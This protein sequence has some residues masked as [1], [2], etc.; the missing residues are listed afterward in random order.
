MNGSNFSRCAISTCAAFSILSGCVGQTPVG[1]PPVTDQN[2]VLGGHRAGA[3]SRFLHRNARGFTVSGRD[4]LLDGKRFF[5]KGVDYGPT[6]A[7]YTYYTT[8]GKLVNDAPVANPLDNA[9]KKIWQADL[10]L[11]R[12]DGINAVKVYNVSLDS[13]KSVP[14]YNDATFQHPSKGETGKIDQFLD[15]AWN[16]GNHPIYVM[17]SIYFEGGALTRPSLKKTYADFYR[18][19]DKEYGAKPA[20][21]GVSISSEI[22]AADYV[23]SADWW[24]AFNTIDAAAKEGF[25]QGGNTN[26]FT[27]TTFV[28]GTTTN[29]SG[30]LVEEAPYFGTKFKSTN[31]TW[32]LDIYR[33]PHLRP[34]HF[35]EQ[36]REATKKP[37]LLGEYG[38]PA[39]WFYESTAKHGPQGHCIDYPEGDPGTPEDVDELLDKPNA[40]PGMQNLVFYITENQKDIFENY[41]SSEAVNSGGFLF[42]FSD[43]W[44]KAGWSRKQ[45]GG[46]HGKIPRNP[47]YASCYNSEAWFGLY[48]DK[49]VNA[50]VD[51]HG[52]LEDQ[53]Y[54]N[55]RQPD[56]RVP[57]KPVIDALTA[58]WNAE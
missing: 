58:L 23:R 33:G 29:E 19:M 16:G 9:Y 51:D 48:A 4:I 25:E 55:G 35:W 45:I 27:T 54:P 43:E 6:N 2:A 7:G 38:N 32:G 11:M 28:D 20:V 21:M 30:D 18:L 50:K 49:P 26:R 13:F 8:D 47:Q 36:V 40:N 12:A 46:A 44:W 3:D 52:N 37:M 15:A 24:K 5:I 53:P 39:A 57:R 22:N 10:D 56:K 42:E 1:T 17:L 14:G 31:D 34:T 41:E